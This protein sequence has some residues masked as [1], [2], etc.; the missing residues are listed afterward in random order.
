MSI[1]LKKAIQ[2]C[3]TKRELNLKRESLYIKQ[4][5][6]KINVLITEKNYTNT[7]FYDYIQKHMHLFHIIINSFS[8]PSFFY[9]YVK[10]PRSI[11]REMK[12]E[13]KN[14]KLKN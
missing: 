1:Y 12:E 13:A 8:M 4:E 5:I 7:F 11:F 6:T 9:M 14:L 3:R 10:I 2:N